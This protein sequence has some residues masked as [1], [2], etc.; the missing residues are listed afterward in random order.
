MGAPIEA[1]PKFHGWVTDFRRRRSGA[2][3]RHRGGPGGGG[4]G[5]GQR[6][7]VDAYVRDLVARL[8]REPGPGLLSA[9]L[10]DDGPDGPVSIAEA[11][12]TPSCCWS[13]GT[14]RR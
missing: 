4:E 11:E 7:Q 13:P 1:E 14:T 3:G 2:G 8:A 9:V 5:G 10:H 12:S 6:G